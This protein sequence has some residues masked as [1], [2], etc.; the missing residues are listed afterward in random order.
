MRV[1]RGVGGRERKSHQGQKLRRIWRTS[2]TKILCWI[3]TS[4]MV[5]MLLSS[6]RSAWYNERRQRGREGER[7][8]RLTPLTHWGDVHHSKVKAMSQLGDGIHNQDRTKARAR[9]HCWYRGC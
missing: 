3:H 7:E 6:S 5:V 4:L 9:P 8:A 2:A 1:G